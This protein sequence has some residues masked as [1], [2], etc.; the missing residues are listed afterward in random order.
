MTLLDVR[1]V[2]VNFPFTPY[3]CQVTYMERVLQCLQQVR[4]NKL[5]I[6]VSI[7]PCLCFEWSFCMCVCMHLSVLCVCVCLSVCL[8]VLCV[9]MLCV[10]VNV[11]ACAELSD[12][13]L[14]PGDNI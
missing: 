6:G 5:I 8:S 3:P 13:S 10:C 9:Y 7:T 4:A 1:G 14:N 11:H 12:L 2:R